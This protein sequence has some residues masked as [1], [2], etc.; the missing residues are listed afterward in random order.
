MKSI[1]R[2]IHSLLC[3]DLVSSVSASSKIFW[4]GLWALQYKGFVMEMVILPSSERR[5][6]RAARCRTRAAHLPRAGWHDRLPA[7]QPNLLAPHSRVVRCSPTRLYSRIINPQ[8]LTLLYF[9]PITD[10]LPEL[11]HIPQIAYLFW[12]L[13]LSILTSLVWYS[14]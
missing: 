8:W 10:I 4:L 6:P 12:L 1:P 3:W 14:L 13:I 7:W 9:H 5:L 2:W 11:H